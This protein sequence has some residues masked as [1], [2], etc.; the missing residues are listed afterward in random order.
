MSELELLEQSLWLRE[1]RFDK[2]YME[3]I[4]DQ[5]FFEF[6]RSGKTYTRSE[7]IDMATQ[8][9]HAKIPLENFAIHVVDQNIRLVTY[10]SEVRN[11]IIERA[12]RSS[13]WVKRNGSW[14][15]RFHQGTAI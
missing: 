1:T 13:L 15:L 2:D 10:V 4:L 8:E 3:H 5:E 6:G 7:C 9:L 12:N 11:C 14:K